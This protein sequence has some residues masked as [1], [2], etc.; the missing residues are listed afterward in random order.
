MTTTE[1][2]LNVITSRTSVRHYNP[3]VKISKEELENILET[4]GKAPSAWNLQHWHFMVFH[5]DASK[6]RLLPIA[7]NQKQI[8]ESSAVI[9]VL[10]D[11]EADKK[12]ET[13]YTPLVDAGF[14]SKE[15]ME[16]L[17]GQI[18]R[19][20]D[21]P[22]NARDAAHTNASLAA[23][24]FILTAK[25]K[26]Y[27]TCS[28]GGF[29]AQKLKEEFA[30]SDRFVPVMLITIGQAAKPAHKSERLPLNEVTT[31]L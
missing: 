30:V 26:G 10:G 7:Y 22:V 6:E 27:D 8:V 13:V 9:A 25:A 4:A 29:D 15:I 21:N 31:W 28:I 24:Q 16:S 19:A 14:M 3:E 18:N 20:Y 23:M 11:L 1:D 12:T 2:L 5:S 17:A